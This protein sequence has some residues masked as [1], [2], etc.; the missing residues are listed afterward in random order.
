MKYKNQPIQRL[1]AWMLLSTYAIFWLMWILHHFIAPE[2]QHKSEICR[3]DTSETY[4]HGEEHADD[5]CALCQ[6]APTL[7]EITYLQISV[8]SCPELKLTQHNF[9][10]TTYLRVALFTIFQPRAPPA[11]I[12]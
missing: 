11:P 6:I 2:H 10:E 7:A 9:G 4:F 8:F 5:D 12:S 1:T 3:H